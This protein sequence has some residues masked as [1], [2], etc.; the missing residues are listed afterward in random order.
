M[1][2]MDCERTIRRR[3]ERLARLPRKSAGFVLGRTPLCN[4]PRGYTS[5]GVRPAALLDSLFEHSVNTA[6]LQESLWL[7]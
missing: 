4:V 5:V 7:N 3:R 6:I 2:T 1:P